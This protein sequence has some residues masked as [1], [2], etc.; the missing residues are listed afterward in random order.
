METIW[1]FWCLVFLS[2][3]T[4]A[5][6]DIND[7]GNFKPCFEG[8]PGGCSSEDLCFQYFCYPKSKM[9]TPLRSCKKPTECKDLGDFKCYKPSPIAGVCVQSADND[10]CEGHDECEGRGGKCCGD[11]CCNEEYFQELL[12]KECSEDDDEGVCSDVQKNL[13]KYEKESLACESN[14]ECE[15]KHTGHKCCSDNPLLKDVL[16]SDET[17]NWEGDKRCCFSA[18]GERQLD[19]IENLTQEDYGLIDGK[20]SE[21]PNKREFCKDLLK[22]LQ[23]SFQT[24]IDEREAEAEEKRT[25]VAEAA[26]AV[27][28]N[29]ATEA[30]DAK[31]KAVGLA[32][33]AKSASDSKEAQGYANDAKMEADNAQASANASSIAAGDAADAGSAGNAAVEAEEA[34]SMAQGDAD[35]A[36]TAAADAQDAADQLKEAEIAAEK[37]KAEEEAKKAK[38]AVLNAATSMKVSTVSVTSALILYHLMS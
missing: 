24:C 8:V 9:E 20:V 30:A 28:P 1:S 5:V 10:M 38:Y 18:T 16:L 17:L 27:A 14:E 32:E 21:L 34:A 6:E 29:H 23:D 26:L 33:S 11:Y 36:D 4:L 35:A 13:I 7:I 15:A 12:K 25:E 31:A 19:E 2:A 22:P 3:S 37:A